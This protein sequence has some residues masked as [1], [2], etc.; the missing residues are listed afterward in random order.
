MTTL[1]PP[2]GQRR[3]RVP[4]RAESV[5]RPKRTRWSREE[6]ARLLQLRREGRSH[7]DIAQAL[8]CSPSRVT[9]RIVRLVRQR[10][11]EPM[12]PSE[13]SRRGGRA[14]ARVRTDRYLP[15]ELDT[16]QS[17]WASGSPMVDI[18]AELGRSVGAVGGMLRH[19]RAAGRVQYLTKEERI[20]RES[21]VRERESRTKAAGARSIVAGLQNTKDFGYIVGLMYGDAYIEQRS[22]CLILKTVEESFARAFAQALADTFGDPPR[23]LSRIEPLKEVSGRQYRDVIFYE[24]HFNRR[25][26]VC[27]LEETFGCT[28]KKGWVLDVDDCMARGRAFCNGLVQ[29]LFDSDGSVSLSGRASA[30]VR[31]GSTNAGGVGALAALMGRM[32]Y[33][34]S[35]GSPSKKGERRVSVLTAS[36]L[37]FAMEIGSR[38]A[39]KAAKLEEMVRR[40]KRRARQRSLF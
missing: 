3:P 12:S 9:S 7:A 21:A 18:A 19:L 35:V 11:A 34:V 23:R 5:G 29:G 20:R 8:G 27:A 39:P 38:V 2:P 14:C 37:R 1:V 15:E 30:S 28:T 22:K 31:F 17:R 33:A 36:Q 4:H 24:A 25:H 26:L 32:G 13:M 10:E 6:D 16:V 40:K